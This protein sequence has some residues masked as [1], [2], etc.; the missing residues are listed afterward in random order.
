MYP[1]IER[2]YTDR[3]PLTVDVTTL[4]RSLWRRPAPQQNYTAQGIA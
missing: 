1:Q 4:Q 3:P 2:E